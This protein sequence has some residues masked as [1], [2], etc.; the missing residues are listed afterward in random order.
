MTPRTGIIVGLV[1]VASLVGATTVRAQSDGMRAVIPF[2]FKAGKATLPAGTYTVSQQG[3]TSNAVQLRTLRGGAFLLP[4]GAKMGVGGQETQLT[5]NRYG[6]QYFLHQ[7]RFS[8]D[9][10]FTLPASLAE[11]EM[12]RAAADA[13]GPGQVLVT[14]AAAR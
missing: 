14:V 2:E 5:F 12:I 11:R 7:I 9:R 4:Q 3:A 10:E 6:D 8:R 1:G 13:H